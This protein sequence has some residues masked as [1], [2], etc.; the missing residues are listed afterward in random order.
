M[1]RQPLIATSPTYFQHAYAQQAAHPQYHDPNF[2]SP[3]YR[4]LQ[5]PLQQQQQQYQLSTDQLALASG[6]HAPNF[7]TPNGLPLRAHTHP[8]LQ[9][10]VM[11]FQDDELAEFQK[12]S[13]DWQPEMKVRVK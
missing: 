11:P 1:Q 9:H 3:G 2:A 4:Q 10:P 12:L 13:N 7:R 6:F 5:L 8:L